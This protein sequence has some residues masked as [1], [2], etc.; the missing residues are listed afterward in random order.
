MNLKT[1]TE[2]QG[3]VEQFNESLLDV[4][5][6][7]LGKKEVDYNTSFSFSKNGHSLILEL[8]QRLSNNGTAASFENIKEETVFEM[9]CSAA[10]VTP[11]EVR[12]AKNVRTERTRIPRQVHLSVLYAT[13]NY[14]GA[15]AGKFYDK[16]HATV[17]YSLK[18]VNQFLETDKEF[19]ETYGDILRLCVQINPKT[20][21]KIEIKYLL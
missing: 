10:N 11:A 8:F 12:K 20:A 6:C 19:R 13:F 4:K 17:L 15:E 21:N 9:I 5:E 1:I 2:L 3:K 14:T 7:L 18:K 16:D